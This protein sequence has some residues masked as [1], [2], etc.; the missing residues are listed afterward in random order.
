MPPFITPPRQYHAEHQQ[1]WA[2]GTIDLDG[3]RTLR[4]ACH[5]KRLG[6]YSGPHPNDNPPFAT[7]A[8]RCL[9]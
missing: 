3:S 2:V 4:L 9:C 8:V 7:A 1:R 6:V 5:R